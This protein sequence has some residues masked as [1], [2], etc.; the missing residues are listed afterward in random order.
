MEIEGIVIR[1]TPF[2][3]KD[4]MI[5]VLT[6]DGIIS[7][8]ARGIMNLDSKN[9]ASLTLY[10]YSRFD[11]SDDKT[12]KSLSLR[13]GTLIKGYEQSFKSLDKLAALSFIGELTI[14]GI[15]DE[16]ASGI[17]QY[18]LKSLEA[19]ESGF[20][21]LTVVLIYFAQ[22]LKVA[23]YGLEVQ[24]CVFCGETKGI[25]TVSYPDGGFVCQNCLDVPSMKPREPRYL[26]IIRY[27]FL[28]STE[29]ITRVAFE[30]EECLGILD[31]FTVYAADVLGANLKSYGLMINAIK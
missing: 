6:Q 14:K 10:A 25:V 12:G 5:N 30:K 9:A 11:F 8:L 3:E 17:Y 27:L 18:A 16:D 4:A 29:D 13:S 19:I 26:K 24:H 23:G 22:V 2:K 1:I 31:E 7:F 28:A 20:D 15:G 21:T